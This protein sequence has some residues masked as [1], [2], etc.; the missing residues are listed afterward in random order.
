MKQHGHFLVEIGTE[1]LPPKALQKLAQALEHSI[2]QS[3]AKHELSYDSIKAY[4]TPRRLAVSIKNLEAKQADR[5][6]ERRGPALTAAFDADG[7]PTPACQGFAKSCGVSIDDLQQQTTDKGTWLAY[8]MAQQGKQTSELM[9]DILQQA[10]KQLPIPKRMRWGD[11]DTEFVRPV[12]W[13]VMLFDDTVVPANILGKDADRISHGHRFHA[14]QPIS[15]PHADDYEALLEQHFVIADFA[16][17]QALIRQQIAD[18]AKT[19]NGTAPVDAGLLDEVTALVEWPV[20]LVAHFDKEFLSVPAEALIS[21]MHG[22]QKCFHIQDDNGALLPYFITISNIESQDK[23]MVI[24][25]NE[26]VM[27]ARLADAKFFYETDLKH[28]LTDQAQQLSH[29][30][31]QKQLGTLAEKTQRI[32]ALAKY[33]AEQCNANSELVERAA[34]LCK[35][36]LMSDMVGEFPELQGIM[37]TYYAQH[38]GEADEV[39][40]AI[41][42]HYLPRYAGDTLPQ[43][44]SG[45]ILAIADRIDTLV[46]IFGI[47]QQPSGEKDPFALRRAALGV[48][49]I[50]IETPLDLDL[51]ALLRYATQLYAD[52]LSNNDVVDQ[53]YDFIIERLKAWYQ[54]QNI[55]AVVFASVLAKRPSHPLDFQ[56]RVAAVNE[57]MHLPQAQALAAANKRVSKLLIKEQQQHIDRALQDDL[58]ELPAEKELA[59]TI[60][61]KRQQLAP[62]FAK[63]DYNTA[64]QELASLQ[65]PVDKFFEEVMV[66]VDDE[67]VRRNRLALLANLRD[68]FLEVADISLL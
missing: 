68:L 20:A 12:H 43:T 4:A 18:A 66:M 32:Q 38:Q 2:T 46:G 19:V 44:H 16:K 31:F 47:N 60:I 42:E 50:I 67:K 23:Q 8:S 11:F 52:K 22:H 51:Q 61:N 56:H 40:Q 3:L 57:F 53:C 41:Q 28:P 36:D 33:M 39:A 34:Y 37:G 29:V 64:L 14:S 13:L 30:L 27:R 21:A 58:F 62:I 49:R 55:N 63:A 25:G 65:Q 5:T 7:N 35:A 10:I 9:P 17:R 15:I 54:E 6:V 45:S 48:L 26:R 59:H 1:E 24:M